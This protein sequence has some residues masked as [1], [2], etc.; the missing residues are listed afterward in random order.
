M[1]ST[2]ITHDEAFQAIEQ[3]VAAGR[4]PN[5]LTLRDKLG[6]RGSGP[7]LSRFLDEWYAEFGPRLAAGADG[8]KRRRPIDRVG[9]QIKQLAN[10]AAQEITAAERARMELLDERERALNA[11]DASLAA[12]EHAL[13]A[14]QARFDER[15]GDLSLL[16]SELRSDKA[17]L[18]DLV[19]KLQADNASLTALNHDLHKHQVAAAADL[20]ELHTR[21]SAER[22]ENAAAIARLEEERHGALA[23]SAG[24]EIALASAQKAADALQSTIAGS[25]NGVERQLQSL[26]L[27]VQ[28]G[29]EAVEAERASLVSV[30]ED[31]ASKLSDATRVI[32]RSIDREVVLVEQEQQHQALQDQLN[33]R[34]LSQQEEL[35]E[36]DRQ[37]QQL[38]AVIEDLR[39]DG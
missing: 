1:A 15:E 4:T 29:A 16:I 25:L 5:H 38:R 6:G 34:L 11:A 28:D 32:Q 13:T 24:L 2:R 23:R 21:V 10:E 12:R 31:T 26:Q 20:A 22:M 27:S 14:E 18:A 37:L 35:G 17:S 9:D 8:A 36:R 33:E 39:R 19:A 7:T 3:L 30:L